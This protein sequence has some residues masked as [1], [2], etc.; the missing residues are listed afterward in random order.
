MLQDA[1][2]PQQGTLQWNGDEPDYRVPLISLLLAIGNPKPSQ[3]ISTANR[4]LAAGEND[5]M[6]NGLIQ[7]YPDHGCNPLRKDRVIGP[8]VE[9]AI[10]NLGSARPGDAHGCDGAVTHKAA[11]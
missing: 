8:G 2:L 7:I 9:Q 3:G 4:L 10:Q 1:R 11:S 5:L 6:V